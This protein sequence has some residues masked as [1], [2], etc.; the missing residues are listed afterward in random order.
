MTQPTI[1]S[2]LYSGTISIFLVGG[3]YVTNILSALI[4]IGGREQL[5]AWEESV[6]NIIVIVIWRRGK[7]K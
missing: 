4:L 5:T 3:S 1:V 2:R 7:R 6:S